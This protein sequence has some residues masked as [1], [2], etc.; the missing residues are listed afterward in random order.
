VTS[1]SYCRTLR[2]PAL[3]GP[4]AYAVTLSWSPATDPATPSAQITYDVYESS[5][6]HG[7]NFSAPTWTT[8]A[9][10]TS[11]MTSPV[12]LPAY[13]VVRAR[14]GAGNEDANT[15]EVQAVDT[16]TGVQ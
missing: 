15:V 6:S 11:Y 1:A 9:G 7:E 13:F 12:A 8:A 10:V 3:P 14:D 4:D 16:C 2:P 5:T